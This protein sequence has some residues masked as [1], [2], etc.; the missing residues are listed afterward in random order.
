M[1]D[2]I[3]SLFFIRRW[4]EK[5]YIML[6]SNTRDIIVSVVHPE[7]NMAYA[8]NSTKRENILL[9]IGC[10]VPNFKVFF[11]CCMEEFKQHRLMKLHVGIFLPK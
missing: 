4:K 1:R 8:V 9:V 7:M 2:A 6:T 11:T 3:T 5:N 10:L